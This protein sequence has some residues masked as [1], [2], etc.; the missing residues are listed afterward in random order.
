MSLRQ[1]RLKYLNYLYSIRRI[2][3]VLVLIFFPL[4]L[5]SL[6]N[7]VLQVR[8]PIE[9]FFAI[10]AFKFGTA[11]GCNHYASLATFVQHHSSNLVAKPTCNASD[12]RVISIYEE[13]E[14]EVEERVRQ[15]R[16]HKQFQN[17]S[18]LST[19]NAG[20]SALSNCNS[21]KT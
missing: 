3:A 14:A 18:P 16:H 17:N 7:S 19:S 20:C 1:K 4:H 13:E 2:I 10:N 15:K 6:R 11:A 5:K 21:L 9:Y 8:G 12:L